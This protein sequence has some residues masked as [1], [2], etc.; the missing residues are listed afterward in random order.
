M[1]GK[2]ERRAEGQKEKGSYNNYVWTE[3][4][5]T[6]T[7]FTHHRHTD[8]LTFS[9]HINGKLTT[10]P[11]LSSPSLLSSPLTLH[12][13][14]HPSHSYLT[15]H[16]HYSPLVTC[17]PSLLSSL[18]TPHSSRHLSPLTPLI[19]HH[20]SLLT[21]LFIPHNPLLLTPRSPLPSPHSTHLLLS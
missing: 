16:S 17:H 11:L 6:F 19:T 5:H 20:T 8:T 21:P 7:N 15:A 10:T 14:P 2:E 9:A 18:V 13:T 4:V 3:V 12:L 1:R